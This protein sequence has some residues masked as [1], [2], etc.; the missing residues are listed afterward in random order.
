MKEFKIKSSNYSFA[1]KGMLVRG[2]VDNGF[3]EIDAYD[4]C[5]INKENM[6]KEQ[7]IACMMH[8]HL[9][10]WNFDLNDL[11]PVKNKITLLEFALLKNYYDKNYRYVARDRNDSLYFYKNCPVKKQ[12]YWA[13]P[14]H[15]GYNY[16]RF[17]LEPFVDLFNFVEWEDD[18]PF[19]I[20]EILKDFE[21]AGYE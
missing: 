18:E 19:T 20:E 1:N 5:T 2:N 8:G 6:S 13:D 10:D 12:D 9:F 3:L 4:F 7:I 14:E 21:V 17:L 11:E 16:A 15:E